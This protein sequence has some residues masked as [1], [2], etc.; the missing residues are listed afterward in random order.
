MKENNPKKK[1]YVYRLVDKDG[2]ELA[3][4]QLKD[5]MSV[6]YERYVYRHIFTDTLFRT[7]ERLYN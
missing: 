3:K 6:E 7:S 5:C 2:K 1:W 4:G